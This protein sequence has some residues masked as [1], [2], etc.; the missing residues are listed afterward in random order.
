VVA[1][2]RP[3]WRWLEQDI[4]LGARVH[5]DEIVRNHSEDGYLVV[6]GTLVPEGTDTVI[7][8]RN[9]GAAVAGAFHLL[10]TVRIK[11]FSIM[12][13]A[14]LEVIGT[15]FE[16]RL[17]GDDAA[18]VNTVFLPGLGMHAQATSWLGV[19]AGVHAGFSPV[20][21]GQP[22]DVQPERSIN[23]EAGLR[24]DHRTKRT[25]T[26]AEAIG[27]LNDYSNLTSVCT[28]SSGCED[29]M[30]DRQFNAGQ[31]WVFGA[32]FLVSERL[33]LPR[34]H[35]IEANVSYTYTGSNFRNSFTSASPQL[36]DVTR[37][38]ELPYVPEHL[39]SLGLGVGGR[40]WGLFPSATYVGQMRDVAGRGAIPVE[41]RIPRHYVVDLAGQVM[42]TKR[43]VLYLNFH[44]LTNNRYMVSRRPFG[45]RPGMPFQLMAGFKYSF[46]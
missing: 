29:D 10:D 33:E 25:R 24:A 23:Y 31:V 13:G 14:R 30:L 37:G 42:P 5:H 2:W 40:L 7:T 21:P 41:E 35:F 26:R 27:F 3:T 32:E 6:S 39:G 1:H 34:Q 45:A 16:D 17:S 12:P 15:Q 19:L 36:S 8:T 22:Q 44:N 9:R 20:S 28:L 43:T 11:W 38:D 46:G 18:A 4:E